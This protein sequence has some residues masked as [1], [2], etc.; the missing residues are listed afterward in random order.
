MNRPGRLPACWQT[1]ERL[2]CRDWNSESQKLIRRDCTGCRRCNKVIAQFRWASSTQQAK[3]RG[4][5]ER[6]A[7]LTYWRDRNGERMGRDGMARLYVE[8]L[9]AAI[10]HQAGSRLADSLGHLLVKNSSGGW[11]GRVDSFLLPASAALH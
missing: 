5:P 3:M 4:L 11:P 8:F 10:S 2:S 6:R 7:R 1:V 9:G